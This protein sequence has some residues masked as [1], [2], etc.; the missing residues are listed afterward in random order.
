MVGDDFKKCEEF[1]V[2]SYIES[3]YDEHEDELAEYDCDNEKM[4]K[5][6]AKLFRSRIRGD[7]V[8]LVKEKR[9]EIKFNLREF[10]I[11]TV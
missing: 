8:S 9:D 10:K 2:F 7:L 1:D 4:R 3:V 5:K 11:V 6:L